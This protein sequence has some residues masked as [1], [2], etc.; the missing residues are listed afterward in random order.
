MNKLNLKT[1]FKKKKQR[2][3]VS[4]VS[5]K[6]DWWLILGLSFF[7]FLFGVIYATHLYLDINNNSLFESL[8]IQ[9]PAQEI[10]SKKQKIKKTVDFIEQ[11]NF[12][13]SALN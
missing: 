3:S 5:I 12:D 2:V 13:E 8:D 6:L 1:Y 10:E 11:R 9:D 7:V 4:G